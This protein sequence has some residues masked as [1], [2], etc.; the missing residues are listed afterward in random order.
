M[1]STDAYACDEWCVGLLNYWLY[2][3][4]RTFCCILRQLREPD[5]MTR[6]E[7][8]ASQQ[9]SSEVVWRSTGTPI[10]VYY[11]HMMWQTFDDEFGVVRMQIDW[12]T[13][14]HGGHERGT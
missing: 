8:V 6:N 2:R 12:V 1:S 5:G 7:R 13:A 3:H 14:M 9:S 4:R 10:V 11:Q